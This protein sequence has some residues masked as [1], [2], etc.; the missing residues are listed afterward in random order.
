MGW[1]DFSLTE[2]MM[3]NAIGRLFA[4]LYHGN[5]GT[6]IKRFSVNKS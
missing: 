1:F 5:L 6:S 3:M 4:R 2:V